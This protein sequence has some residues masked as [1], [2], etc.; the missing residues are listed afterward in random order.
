M[1]GTRLAGSRFRRGRSWSAWSPPTKAARPAKGSSQALQAFARFAETHDDA[2][3]YLHTLL[4]PDLAGGENLPGLIRELGI[5]LNRIRM[6]DQYSMLYEPYSPDDMAKIYSR[7]GRAA[8]PVVGRRL[9]DPDHRGAGVWDAG[10]RDGVLVDA[11]AVR[12][13][14]AGQ[15]LAGSGPGSG[16]GRLSRTWTTS[17]DSLEQCYARSATDVERDGQ[18]ARA[19]AEQYSVERVFKQHWLP[20]LQD[21]GA[22]V[23]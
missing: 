18:V 21:G 20:A 15:A 5:P 13:G 17:S 23:R 10:D 16:R 7:H 2:F 12:V 4:N 3:L 22:A 1:T 14:L 6:A 11:G 19:F 8:Q 9:R